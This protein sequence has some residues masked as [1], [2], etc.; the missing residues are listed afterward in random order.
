MQKVTIKRLS[1]IWSK[2]T[3]GQH[4]RKPRE[5]GGEMPETQIQE[6]RTR[7]WGWLYIWSHQTSLSSLCILPQWPSEF[8]GVFVNVWCLLK[9]C[10]FEL[11]CKIPLWCGPLTM[12]L[13]SF[14]HS[15]VSQSRPYWDFSSHNSFLCVLCIVWCLA[16]SLDST[17]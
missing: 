8:E 16:A 3:T 15:R 13:P 1:K 2:P 11:Y 5:M 7:K 12:V 14:Y 9:N 10:W 6:E 17:H 4:F